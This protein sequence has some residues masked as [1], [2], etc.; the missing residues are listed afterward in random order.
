MAKFI[1]LSLC[2]FYDRNDHLSPSPEKYFGLFL[3]MNNLLCDSMMS[4]NQMFHKSDF[5]TE[6]ALF[7]RR[8]LNP[9]AYTSWLVYMFSIQN[10]RISFRDHLAL[11]HWG[12]LMWDEFSKTRNIQVRFYSQ[13][14][15]SRKT[16]R[17]IL[18]RS[19]QL[20]SIQLFPT[21]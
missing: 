8:W 11:M 18:Q 5:Y 6:P 14:Q 3:I 21:F 16:R 20:Y 2:C 10:R 1:F 19:S 9:C 13:T 15:I 12:L 17:N 7:H 4:T